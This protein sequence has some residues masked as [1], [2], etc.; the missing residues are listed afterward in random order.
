MIEEIIKK[1]AKQYFKRYLFSNFNEQKYGIYVTAVVAPD[2]AA[3][4]MPAAVGDVQLGFPVYPA[5]GSQEQEE[6]L[7]SSEL[8]G[9]SLAIPGRSCKHLAAPADPGIP[10]LLRTDSRQE[11]CPPGCS[12][13]RPSCDCGPGHLRT[14]GGP[15]S[16]QG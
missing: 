9:W 12:S 10:L 8:T 15:G 14:V 4:M 1:P 7:P 16:Q 5:G 6:A 13:S 3:A 2:V 11:T